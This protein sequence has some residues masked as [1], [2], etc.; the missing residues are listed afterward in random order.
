MIAGAGTNPPAMSASP[1]WKNGVAASSSGGANPKTASSS[2]RSAGELMRMTI[3]LS[4][5]ESTLG[6]ILE[7]RC[8]ESSSHSPN[9]RPSAAIWI[10]R[11]VVSR[12]SWVAG[13]AETTLCASSITISRGLR[14]ARSAHRSSS[15]ASETASCSSCVCRLPR[16]TTTARGPSSSTSLTD[17]PTPAHTSQ[18]RIPRFSTRWAS[19]S[20]SGSPVARRAEGIECGLSMPSA[21]MLR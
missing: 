12:W 9:L 20:A 19:R 1:W 3:T 4:H 6:W 18:S 15:R 8:V 5:C 14:V 16:S 7:G 13:S 17:C 11:S 2:T 10:T 21:A